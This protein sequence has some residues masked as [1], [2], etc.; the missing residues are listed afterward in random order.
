MEPIFVSGLACIVKGVGLDAGPLEFNL[1]LVTSATTPQG[2]RVAKGIE[3]RNINTN[4]W[5]GTVAT[6]NLFG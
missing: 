1:N 3:D 4:V 2:R 6:D 5:Q